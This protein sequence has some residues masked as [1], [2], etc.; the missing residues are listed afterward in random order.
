MA[1]MPARTM[2]LEK[3]VED[4]INQQAKGDNFTQKFE[5]IVTQYF[6]T[7]PERTQKIKVLDEQIAAKQKELNQIV[8]HIWNLRAVKERI[9]TILANFNLI[10]KEIKNM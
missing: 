7:I 8:K 2:R 5:Y 4:L 6:Y 3:E 1:K 9:D 10:E